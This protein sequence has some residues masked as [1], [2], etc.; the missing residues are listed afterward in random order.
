MNFKIGGEFRYRISIGGFFDKSK[1]EFPDYHHLAGNLTRNAAPYLQ[2]FQ[3]APFYKF[4][5]KEK[6][7][8]AMF[9]EYKLN[10]LLTN[11]IPVLKK[12]NLRLITGTNMIYLERDKLYNEIFLGFDNVL[13]IL[14][15]DYVIGFQQ[16][17]QAGQGLR[18]GIKGFSSLFTDY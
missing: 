4:S 2:T 9:T 6:I 11:K 8:Y 12:L 10:G 13:K 17:K 14:R 18:I 3:I 7:Y 5:N 16:G 1:L 15:L